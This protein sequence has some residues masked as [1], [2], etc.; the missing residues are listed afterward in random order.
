MRER[1]KDNLNLIHDLDDKITF[2]DDDY[3]NNNKNVGQLNI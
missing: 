2:D 1:I 3:E